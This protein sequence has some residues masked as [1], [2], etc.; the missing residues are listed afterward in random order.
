LK[1]CPAFDTAAN[2]VM[3][4]SGGVPYILFDLANFPGYPPQINILCDNAL[5]IGYRERHEKIG[6]PLIKKTVNDL[7]WLPAA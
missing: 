1:D 4:G 3:Q 2:D 6:S 5:L 7:R